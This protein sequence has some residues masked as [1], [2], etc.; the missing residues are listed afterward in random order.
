V[1]TV[2]P[3][4]NLKSATAISPTEIRVV[5]TSRGDGGSPILER[6]IGYGTN[7]VGP[8]YSTS[9]DGDTVV[10]GFNS[11]QS[12][13]FWARVRN[14]IGW[15]AWS[16]RRVATTFKGPV[17]PSA[18]AFSLITQTS[19]RAKFTDKKND[20]NEIIERQIAYGLDPNTPT[21]SVSAT[22]GVKDIAGLEPGKVYYFWARSRNSVGWGPYS[23]RS[24]LT[25][26]AGARIFTVPG[27]WRRA[28][29]YV[30]VDG[31]WR[32]VQ[33]YVKVSGVW[34]KTL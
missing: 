15:S 31:V 14:A 32:R 2:P 13:F 20:K 6:Q 27:G 19:V 26:I 21:T 25:L 30:K 28:V 1:A 33:P 12:V 23:T 22:T 17:A 24:I 11:G 4:P 34:R 9:S 18:V 5:I 7:G 29:A 10:G 3:Y 8:T 16:V